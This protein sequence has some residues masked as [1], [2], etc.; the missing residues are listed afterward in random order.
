MAYSLYGHQVYTIKIL[1]SQLV[2]IKVF[3]GILIDPF[4]WLVGRLELLLIFIAVNGLPDRFFNFNITGC[5]LLLVLF[6]KVKFLLKCKK[7]IRPF[8]ALQCFGYL[9]F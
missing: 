6:V 7:I 5:N 4:M 8:V 1:I 2:K 9:C 3:W